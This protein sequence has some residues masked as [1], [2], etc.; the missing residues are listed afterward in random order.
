MRRPPASAAHAHERLP[1]EGDRRR[2]AWL[3][4]VQQHAAFPLA[5]A[6]LQEGL[7]SF[8][9]AAGYVAFLRVLGRPLVL[10]EPVSPPGQR[11]GLLAA[12]LHHHPGAQFCCLTEEAARELD[13]VSGGAYRFAAVGV[14]RHVRVLD[15]TPDRSAPLGPALRA[16]D[17]ARI[18]LREVDWAR[19]DPAL[20]AQLRGVDQRH[21]SGRRA[22]G[23]MRFLNRPARLTDERPSRT[24]VLERREG[25]R[26]RIL[27][28]SSLDPFRARSGAR[29]YQVG[30][31]RFEPTRL[32][33]LLALLGLLQPL[34]A[35]EG[36]EELALGLSPLHHMHPPGDLPVA[37]LLRAQLAWLERCRPPV[38][39][40]DRLRQL[41][42]SLVG[43]DRVQLAAVTARHSALLPVR[44]AVACGL[45]RK[46]PGTAWPRTP[47]RVGERA[48][49]E[50]ARGR[51]VLAH[52]DAVRC[53]L[54]DTA[55]AF[56]IDRGAHGA[57][58]LPGAPQRPG[59]W[60][61]ERRRLRAELQRAAVRPLGGALRSLASSVLSG[62]R[63][64]W[65][66]GRTVAVHRALGPLARAVLG[67]GVQP[68]GAGLAPAAAALPPGGAGA[69]L[70][71]GLGRVLRGVAEHA[72]VQRRLHAE[73]G[74][75]SSQYAWDVV[76]E[77]LRLAPI[78]SAVGFR[79]VRTTRVC[80]THVAKGA[81]VWLI[82]GTLH[83]R[84]D[85]WAAPAQF[86]PELNFSAASARVRVPGAYV[87]FGVGAGHA[88]GIRLVRPLLVVFLR[89]LFREPFTLQL[90]E[91]PL[92]AAAH[93][94]R[95]GGLWLSAKGAR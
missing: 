33:V 75:A 27:G 13:L 95:P 64:Q 66:S 81:R 8:Q 82:P 25:P 71:R 55:R 37:T 59:E 91:G 15:L 44:V 14:E 36:V 93:R 34:L 85:V 62:W 56:V 48:V 88:L 45:G 28:F 54:F 31:L 73:A 29:G 50:D 61:D 40:L 90:A 7:D 87:P 32:P 16:A 86:A 11:P 77:C 58:A 78:C 53:V 63:E 2:A 17:A 9:T 69:L 30:V 89:E 23:H 35:A 18:V 4:L 70:A 52:P 49:V 39:S 26:T 79:A 38:G 3:A 92:A 57:R 20:V 1:R 80:G 67:V 60:L 72:G 5:A 51:Q 46:P 12:F 24:F 42:E 65:R 47:S 76:D 10:G 22:L 68:E 19:A 43:A 84:P 21:L 41:K 83:V 94:L 6:T 74:E